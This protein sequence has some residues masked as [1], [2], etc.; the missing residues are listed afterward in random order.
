MRKICYIFLAAALMSSCTVK[1][2]R[3]RCP[4]FLG[5]TVTFQPEFI[6][7]DGKA[8]CSVFNEDGSVLEADALD[9]MNLRDTTIWYT[10]QPRRTVTAVVSN[11]EMASGSVTAQAGEE[12]TELYAFRK[13]VVCLEENVEE[14][15]YRQ[16]KQFCNLSVQL[17]EVAM[18]L[19][20]ELVVRVDAPYDGTSFPSMLA[21]PGDYVYR[22]VFDTDG[23]ASIRLPRQGG[24]GMRL[25]VQKMDHFTNT[26]NLYEEMRRA[27]YDWTTSS[28]LDFEIT[29]SLNSVTGDI[30]LV[31]WTVVDKGDY[32]F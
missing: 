21:H 20:P 18:P 6:F 9:G 14:V 8:W 32:E 3:D 5:L 19:A 17:S 4:S 29:V 27:H 15:I 16:D 2:H 23:R 10:I 31:D 25:S 22:T 11:R 30:E 12:F 26:V 24:E 13:D 28:L 7:R 1:E